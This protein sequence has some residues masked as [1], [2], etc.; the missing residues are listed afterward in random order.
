MARLAP[1]PGRI[2]DR[3]VFERSVVLR[4]DQ[5]TFVH[6]FAVAEAHVGDL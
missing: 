5:G 1:F 4:G 3:A 2:D 6:G